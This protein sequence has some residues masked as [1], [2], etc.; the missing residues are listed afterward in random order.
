VGARRFLNNIVQ[1]P[2]CGA[3]FGPG[4]FAAVDQ[5]TLCGASLASLVSRDV[6]HITQVCVAR[7]YQGTGLGYELMRRSMNA[8]AAHGCR[9]VSLTVT[10]ANESALRLYRNMGFAPRR[11]F[12][13]FVWQP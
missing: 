9:A 1:Y 7:S 8:L 10:A 12:Q 4:S 3:F 5:Q 2:G 11:P 6:G 13:A